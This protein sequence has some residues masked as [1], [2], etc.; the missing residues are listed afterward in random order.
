MFCGFFSTGFSNGESKQKTAPDPGEVGASAQKNPKTLFQTSQ[1]YHEGIAIPTDAVILHRHGADSADLASN[2]K[3]WLEKGY[4][5]QRMFFADSDA[6][7]IYTKGGFDG[8]EHM[9]DIEQDKEGNPILCGGDRPYMVPTQGWIDYLK[10]QV[11]YALDA[12]ALAI[13]PEEPLAHKFTGYEESFKTLFTAEYSIPWKGGHE[14]PDAFF[15]TCR[16]KSNL[17]FKLEQELQ[18]YTNEF[19][20]TRGS[21]A[22]FYIPIHSMYSNLSARLVAPLGTSL[23]IK[24]HKG[25]IGQIWTG[26]VLWTLDNFSDKDTGFFEAAYVLYDYFVNL[27]KG[28]DLTLY[29][30][31]DP[32]EDH[33]G[34]TWPDYESWYKECVTAQLLFGCVNTYEVMPWPERIFLPGYS[35]GGGTPG[36]AHY[37]TIILSVLTAL[38]DMP[39]T[40]EDISTSGCGIGVLIG[41]TAMWQYRQGNLL[42]P[43]LSLLVPLIKQ[44]IPVSTVPIERSGD[45]NYMN[46]F[47]MLVLCYDA[48]KPEK[49]E[50]HDYLAQ[51]IEK[52]GTLIL[53]D[54]KDAFD[55]IDMFWKQ[56]EFPN[57]QTHLL[58]R[59]GIDY[60]GMKSNASNAVT[61]YFSRKIG[62]GGIAVYPLSPESMAQNSRKKDEYLNLIQELMRRHT[63]KKWEPG[64]FFHLKRGNFN[65]CHTFE[66]EQ[67]LKGCYIDIFSA[68]LKVVRDVYL[69]KNTS[70]LLYDI[71]AMLGNPHPCILY[72]TYRLMEKTESKEE[73]AFIIRGPRGTEGKVRIFTAGKKPEKIEAHTVK[74]DAIEPVISLDG[75]Q[76]L[77]MGFPYDAEGV[78][79]RI[80]WK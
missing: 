52:G 22:D 39:L 29:L 72:A 55:D 57:P 60:K 25:Y 80:E 43:F 27:V 46:R 66:T 10:T 28:T 56:K 12:G 69:K 40:E 23:S 19:R 9:G 62:K 24:G 11:K 74:G 20:G 4:A 47:K 34:R 1:P 59:L 32:V 58:S 68:D 76:S 36:P 18:E 17:Y 7:N 65:I 54:G 64:K 15:K 48:W 21:P 41:D 78:K 8:K 3:T 42:D 26:P 35:T 61:G 38:Q 31:T 45:E 75:D 77:L 51:W 6:G 37:R 5:A 63:G 2:L 67:S 79:F 16:L 30:L 33:P 44:G 71:G 49:E 50:Y 73:T 53:F 70:V 13:Y 14:S